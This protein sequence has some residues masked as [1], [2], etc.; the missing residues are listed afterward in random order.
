MAFTRLRM[1]QHQNSFQ[2][3]KTVHISA[4]SHALKQSITSTEQYLAGMLLVMGSTEHPHTATNYIHGSTQTRLST[5]KMT[6]RMCM[7]VCLK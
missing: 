6:V 2:S 3:S 5:N 4:T 1:N 7:F